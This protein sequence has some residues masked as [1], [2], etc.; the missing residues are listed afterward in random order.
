MVKHTDAEVYDFRRPTTLAR[1]HS[2][3]LELAFETFAR[4]W[5]TQL[6]ANT[7]TRSTIIFDNI[8]METYDEYAASLPATTAMVLCSLGEGR[9]NKAVLQ[10]PPTLALSWFSY[11]F[12]GNGNPPENQRPFTRV[13]QSLMKK[14]TNDI[15]DDLRYCMGPLLNGIDINYDSIHHN[16]QFAQA[17][18]TTDLVLVATFSVT[19]GDKNANA[20]LVFPAEVLLTNLGEANP[21]MSPANAKQLLTSQ[22]GHIPVEVALEIPAVGITPS[23]VLGLKVGDVINLE[24]HNSL[25]LDLTVG[26]EPVAQAAMGTNG[27]RL[28]CVVTESQENNE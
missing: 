5:G 26:G 21:V 11:M 14:L 3:T 4:Q 9:S 1:E 13:E 15:L 23:R 28:A 17:A 10:L 2:R 20:T 19:T 25:P 8:V 24:H 16:S 12:G 22:M 27:A 6:T 18:G 7:R